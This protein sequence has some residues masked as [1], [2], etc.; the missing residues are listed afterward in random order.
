MCSVFLEKDYHDV[1]R[2]AVSREQEGVRQV[3]F[4]SPE[5]LV[6]IVYILW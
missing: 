1:L 2:F 5:K 4:I 6:L 3:D